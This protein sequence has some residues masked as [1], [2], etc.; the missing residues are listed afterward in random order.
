MQVI[1]K[2]LDP[3]TVNVPVGMACF[4]LSFLEMEAVK[5]TIVTY[6]LDL[7]SVPKSSS[8]EQ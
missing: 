3:T 4:Q 8:S 7:S 6:T 1:E 2:G 5:Q